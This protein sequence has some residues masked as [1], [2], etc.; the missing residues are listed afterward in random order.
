MKQ[1]VNTLVNCLYVT[2][3]GVRKYFLE[4]TLLKFGILCQLQN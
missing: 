3:V 2:H 4:T 1:H